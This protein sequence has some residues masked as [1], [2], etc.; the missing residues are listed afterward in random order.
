VSMN[1]TNSNLVVLGDETKSGYIDW[2]TSGKSLT[3]STDSKLC[4]NLNGVDLNETSTL[5]DA[6]I[7]TNNGQLIFYPSR[8][9]MVKLPAAVE[10]KIIYIDDFVAFLNKCNVNT[11]GLPEGHSMKQ[12]IDS[13]SEIVEIVEY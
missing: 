2:K 5:T 3:I 4:I 6:S 8:I 11:S 9:D 1:L 7:L 12:F 10:G 13:S